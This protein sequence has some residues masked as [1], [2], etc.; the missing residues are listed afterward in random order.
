MLVTLTL[1]A[2]AIVREKEIGT[3]EQLMVTPIRPIEL[4]I[5]KT[6]PF[7]AIGLVQLVGITTAA[8]LIF[9]VPLNGSPLLLLF[10]SIL[11]IACSLGMGLFIS[12]ISNTQQQAMM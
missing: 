3:M 8:L 5:G 4:I 10:S 7:A 11:F 9:H 2:M 1:T 12:T 6:L